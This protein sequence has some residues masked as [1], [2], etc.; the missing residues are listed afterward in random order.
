MIGFVVTQKGGGSSQLR[1]FCPEVM[2]LP[3]VNSRP[4]ADG[5]G[6]GGIGEVVQF[7]GPSGTALERG[8]SPRAPPFHGMTKNLKQTQKPENFLFLLERRIEVSA[9][10]G[11]Q[12]NVG[13]SLVPPPHRRNSATPLAAIHFSEPVPS[14]SVASTISGGLLRTSPAPCSQP[15]CGLQGKHDF[16]HLEAQRATGTCPSLGELD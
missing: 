14:A 16:P 2:P 4:K 12:R 13:G 15:H 5:L 8:C 6:F 11:V 3:G 10:P 7:F 1:N 9:C